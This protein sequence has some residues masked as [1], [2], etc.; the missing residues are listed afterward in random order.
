MWN[1]I[2]R[3]SLFY[4]VIF[5]VLQIVVILGCINRSYSQKIEKK[6][7]QVAALA[8]DVDLLKERKRKIIYI[9][10]KGD[11]TLNHRA[12]ATSSELNQIFSRVTTFNSGHQYHENREYAKNY[13]IEG[14]FFDEFLQPDRDATGNSYVNGLDLKVETDKV[15]VYPL[16]ANSYYVI[17]R[18]IPYHASSDLNDKSQLKICSTAFA[19][20]AL[21][22]H[23][24]NVRV[25]GALNSADGVH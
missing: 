13:F 14:N 23:K 1:E 17:A 5:V 19:V 15:Y 3:H 22:N 4:I 2:K 16:K 12:E 25:Q 21:G 10:K 8:N 9:P 6:Q 20:T 7:S 11:A 18:Y 24:Y